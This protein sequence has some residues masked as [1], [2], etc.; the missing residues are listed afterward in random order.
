MLLEPIFE[1]EF[2]TRSYGFRKGK[3]AHLALRNLRNNI[4][5]KDG[6]FILDIDIKSYF[7]S[8]NHMW[9]RKALKTRMTDG[10]ISCMIDKWLKAGVMED[11]VLSRNHLGT[12]QGGVISPLLANIF[13]HFVLD[14]W[15]FRVVKPRLKGESSMVRFADDFVM[16]FS[17]YDSA[18]RVFKVL[19]KRLGKFGLELHPEKSKIVDFRHSGKSK[20]TFPTNFSFLGFTHVWKKSRNNKW[21]VLQRTAKD[22]LSRSLK[23]IH[24]FC[25]G[26]RHDSIETQHKKLW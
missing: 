5:D 12:P 11:G 2:L 1:Q 14:L 18:K 13:L 6:R 26:F 4:M 20:A 25:K 9:L 23:S 3:S 17:N 19:G 15:F 8:I 24:N 22:R 7:D 16:I 10:V 21:T